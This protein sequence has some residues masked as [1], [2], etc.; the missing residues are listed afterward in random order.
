MK[1][2][3]N[4]LSLISGGN[5]AAGVDFSGDVAVR[6]SGSYYAERMIWKCHSFGTRVDTCYGSMEDGYEVASDVVWLS[7]DTFNNR[8][9]ISAAIACHEVGHA[10]VSKLGVKGSEYQIEL[11]ATTEALTF[12]AGELNAAQIAV[13]QKFL[14][15]ALATYRK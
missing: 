3:K 11:Y 5:S 1:I 2:L 12:L 10:I 13:A 4:I 8:T 15:Q 7:V 6:Y 9:A 14:T